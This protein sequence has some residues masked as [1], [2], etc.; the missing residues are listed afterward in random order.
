MVGY[1]GPHLVGNSSP[2]QTDCIMVTMYGVVNISKGDE[3]AQWRQRRKTSRQNLK[4]RTNVSRDTMLSVSLRDDV[5]MGLM[6]ALH[7]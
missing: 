2:I 7:A 4:C 3:G 6:M 1:S 5:I